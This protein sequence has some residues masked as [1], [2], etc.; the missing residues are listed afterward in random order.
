MKARQV[1]ML[2]AALDLLVALSW[3]Q[4]NSVHGRTVVAYG[5]EVDTGS[6]VLATVTLPDNLDL[7]SDQELPYKV[8]ARGASDPS[9]GR[10]GTILYWRQGKLWRY[11]GSDYQF[12]LD[13]MEPESGN[14][15]EPLGQSEASR[16]IATI[17][18]VNSDG[19]SRKSIFFFDNHSLSY[20]PSATLNPVAAPV[21]QCE[22]N[23]ESIAWIDQKRLLI[24]EF[25][26]DPLGRLTSS[27][28]VVLTV[29]QHGAK[30]EV[31]ISRV[32]PL[33]PTNLEVEADLRTQNI[34]VVVFDDRAAKFRIGVPDI[35]SAQDH[36]K[37]VCPL[38]GSWSERVHLKW[39]PSCKYLAVLSEKVVSIWDPPHR[40]WLSNIRGYT[41]FAAAEN[42]FWLDDDH[43]LTFSP[44]SSG[45]YTSL[46]FGRPSKFDKSATVFGTLRGLVVSE[47]FSLPDAPPK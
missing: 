11:T 21:L 23:R 12:I 19:I 20:S 18:G 17:V 26:V 24:R 22:W 31:S 2:A 34:A 3:W 35:N 14:A 6:M 39:S 28:F 4:A 8:I 36:P 30:T 40:H 7:Q 38:F 32:T 41:G 37:W 9:E 45:D 1:F 47:V 16:W 25:Q 15:A 29:L 27:R 13:Q 10:A 46:C 33:A 42:V 44:S 43:L 5:R